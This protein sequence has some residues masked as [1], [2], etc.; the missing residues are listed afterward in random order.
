[1]L[2]M[3]VMAK[4]PVPGRVKTRLC[5]PL[6]SGEAAALAAGLCPPLTSGEAAALAAAALM[7]PMDAV[8]ALPAAIGR[9]VNRILALDGSLVDAVDGLGIAGRLRST[10]D[11]SGWGR[12]PQRGTSFAVRLVLAHS[13]AAGAGAVVQVGMDTPQ[14]TPDLLGEAAAT[15]SSRSVDAV[16]GPAADGGW[17]ALGVRDARMTRALGNVPMSTPDTGELTVRALRDDGLRVAVLPVLTDVDTVPDAF[18]VSAAAPDTR[19]ARR[20]RGLV[21]R[22]A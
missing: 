5:P 10:P 3:L 16:I 15:V 4:A 8:D 12:I 22:A 2:T 11:R 1:M 21:E 19:F 7:D 6:T 18:T 9:P 13:D 14:L 17:W 20:F